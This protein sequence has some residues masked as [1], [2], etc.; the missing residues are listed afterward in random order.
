[1]IKSKTINLKISLK[2][3]DEIVSTKDNFVKANSI[4][5]RSKK[6]KPMEG[7]PLTA[8]VCYGMNL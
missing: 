4:R 3:N 7:T 2:R 5:R 6:Y 8:K 1:M